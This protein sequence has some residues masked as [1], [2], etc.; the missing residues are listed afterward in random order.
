MSKNNVDRVLHCMTKD[1]MFYP[2]E[3]IGANK[4]NNEG[5]YQR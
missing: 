1:Y 2:Q 5:L 4:I 3:F